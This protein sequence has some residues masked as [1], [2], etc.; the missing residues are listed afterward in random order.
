[1]DFLFGA[2]TST[3]DTSSTP[4]IIN[5]NLAYLTAEKVEAQSS[6]TT[7]PP[8]ASSQIVDSLPAYSVEP[9]CLWRSLNSIEV[10]LLVD[11]VNNLY[12]LTSADMAYQYTYGYGGTDAKQT[13]ASPP[14]ANTALTSGLKAGKMLRREFVSLVS[15][16][17][18]NP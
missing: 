8:M 11:S 16:R 18:F 17:N 6:P 13:P 14:S 12:D 5:A 3:I 15:V 7:C 10:H 2:Q 4:P 9:G 1:M